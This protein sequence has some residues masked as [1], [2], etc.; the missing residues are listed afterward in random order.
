MKAS[1]YI[2]MRVSKYGEKYRKKKTNQE[3]KKGEQLKKKKKK[4]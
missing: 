1:H 4:A 3:S 2:S